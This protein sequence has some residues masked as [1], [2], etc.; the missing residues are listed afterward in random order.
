MKQALTVTLCMVT[1][2]IA[3]QQNTIVKEKFHYGNVQQD[4]SAGYAGVVKVDNILYLSGITATGNFADQVQKIYSRIDANLKKFGATFQ[5]VVKENLYTTNMDS[6]KFYNYI[7]KPFY[8]S[9]FPAATWVQISKLY[10]SDRMLEVEVVAHLPEKENS[11]AAIPFEKL[12]GTWTMINK[13]G[14]LMGETWKKKN[15]YSMIGKSYMVKGADTTILETVDLLQDGTDMFYIP[16][17][18]GQNDDKPVRFKLTSCT[19][20][21]YTFENPAH[22]FPKRIVYNFISNNELHAYIDDGSENKRQHYHYKKQ[23][24]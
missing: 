5:N 3:A 15:D 18:F 23:K 9:D 19:G 17:A 2:T 16:V 24:G 21:V 10:V 12:T 13:K 14:N 1:A 6:M 11:G 20:T 22:D 4:T 7:R 8:G